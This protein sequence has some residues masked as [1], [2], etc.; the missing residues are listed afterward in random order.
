MCVDRNR[1]VREREYSPG[2]FT[3][4]P[5]YNDMHARIIVNNYVCYIRYRQA[6]V[7]GTPSAISIFAKVEQATVSGPRLGWGSGTLS[8]LC[9]INA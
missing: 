9:V 1:T 3:T 4:L 7:P 8:A 6:A 2:R 5:A